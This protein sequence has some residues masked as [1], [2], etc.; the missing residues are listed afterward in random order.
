[1]KKNKI[2]LSKKWVEDALE[3]CKNTGM[4]STNVYMRRFKI[5]WECAEVLKERV[6]EEIEWEKMRDDKSKE[7]T[8]LSDG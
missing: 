1:M 4:N 8:S 3:S 5:T 7:M 6:I 2:R